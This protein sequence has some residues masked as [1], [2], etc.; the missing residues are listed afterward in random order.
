MDSCEIRLLDGDCHSGLSVPSVEAH[1]HSQR[2][3]ELHVSPVVV[4]LHVVPAAKA[5]RGCDGQDQPLSLSSAFEL[6]CYHTFTK[7]V[8]IATSAEASLAW[9]QTPRMCACMHHTRLRSHQKLS[10]KT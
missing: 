6:A 10:A 4:E 7:S 5:P 8:S 1:P 3:H 2:L 9:T